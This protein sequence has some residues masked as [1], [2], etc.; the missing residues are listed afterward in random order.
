MGSSSCQLGLVVLLDR[1]QHSIDFRACTEDLV[2]QGLDPGAQRFETFVWD[3]QI[4]S[5]GQRAPL[6]AGR[7]R[8][9]GVAGDQGASAS[10]EVT[11][12]TPQLQTS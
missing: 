12:V 1:V 5:N 11:I 9:F 8:V 10:L 4:F 7:Y 3:G 2:E 6:P